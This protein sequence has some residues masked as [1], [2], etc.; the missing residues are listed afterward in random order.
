MNFRAFFAVLAVG[1]VYLSWLQSPPYVRLFEANNEAIRSLLGTLPGKVV[2]AL[3]V[4]HA[5]RAG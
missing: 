3:K 1:I 5:S 2:A 4:N